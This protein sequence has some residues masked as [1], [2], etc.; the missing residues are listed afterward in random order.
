MLKAADMGS[1]SCLL[2]SMFHLM[3]RNPGN[4]CDG[5]TKPFKLLSDFSFPLSGIMS[6]L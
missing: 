3:I 2:R 1:R 6:H 5:D 4:L